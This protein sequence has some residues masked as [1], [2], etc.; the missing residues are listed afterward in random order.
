MILRVLNRISGRIL[1]FLLMALFFTDTGAVHTAGAASTTRPNIILF[2]VDDMGWQETS[3]PFHRERTLLNARYHTPAMERLAKEGI[4]F[5]RAYASAVCSPTRISIISGMNA[6]RHAVTNWTLRKGIS[7]DDPHQ[8]ILPPVWNVNGATTLSGVERTVQV[9]PLAEL[10]RKGG[11]RTI[12]VGKAH[13]GA[14]GTP[15]EDPRHFGFDVN[16]GGHAA[17]APGSYYGERNFSAAWRSTDQ[18]RADADRIW[19]VP[20]LEKWHGREVNLTEVLTTE[21]IL[22]MEQAAGEGRP[23]FLNLSHYAVH[24]PWEEDKRFYQKYIDRGLAP[25]EAMRASMIEGMDRSLGDLLAALDRL[26]VAGRTL[27]I[28]ASDNGAP[29]AVPPNLPLRAWKLAPYEGGIR[30]PMIFRWPEK[31]R[32][33]QTHS[34][35]VIIEDL[36]PTIL[37]AAGIAYRGRTIQ[38]VDGRSLIAVLSGGEDRA[39]VERPLIFHFPHQYYGQGPFSAIIRGDWKLIHHYDN[40]QE[41]LFNIA[42]DTGETSDLARVDRRRAAALAKRL[43]SELARM[44]AQKPTNRST[45]RELPSPGRPA[46]YN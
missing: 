18:G 38:Q 8:T 45:G 12:H 44:G 36:F 28:F 14:Q 11:Y 32:P 19:D 21:A 20:G 41:E 3:V 39:A 4:K 46:A 22:A 6:A 7:P 24:S 9:T 15:G 31:F 35:N 5:S 27:L 17:G 42:S 13:F 34:Q 33:G 23:F 37:D 29:Q 43:S 2:L 1:G 30:I 25:R 10:L 26:G 40:S 16:V